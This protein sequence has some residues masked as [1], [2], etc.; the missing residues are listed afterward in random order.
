MTQSKFRGNDGNTTKR[1]SRGN[2]GN[3]DAE[4]L[5][6]ALKEA[7]AELNSYS[8]DETGEEYNNPRFNDILAA[9]ERAAIVP[10]EP[11]QPAGAPYNSDLENEPAFMHPAQQDEKAGQVSDMVLVPRTLLEWAKQHIDIY[12]TPAEFREPIKSELASY[13]AVPEGKTLGTSTPEASELPPLGD[14]I[15]ARL[16]AIYDLDGWNDHATAREN[17]ANMGNVFTALRELMADVHDMASAA[18]AAR[19]PVTSVGSIGDDLT[20]CD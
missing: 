11:L 20:F 12:V 13:I 7:I 3:T 10:K 9:T 18:F 2:E 4:V 17:A 1:T 16:Q 6:E 8:L 15:Y 19:S 14:E 5:R